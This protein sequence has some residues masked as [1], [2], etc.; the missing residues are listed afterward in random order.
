MF[1]AKRKAETKQEFMRQLRGRKAELA[2]LFGLASSSAQVSRL[3]NDLHSASTLPA[4]G[5]ENTSRPDRGETQE[6]SSH[7][8][9][10]QS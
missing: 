2:K 1:R 6:G 7:G 9:G 4:K 8:F 3:T 5:G 10:S